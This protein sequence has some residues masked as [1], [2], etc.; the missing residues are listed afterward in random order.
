M[1]RRLVLAIVGVAAGAVAL[2]G[3]PLA[4]VL[5]NAYRG[6]ALLRLQRDAV[7]VTRSVDLSGPA[8]DPVELPAVTGVQ[9]SVY[10]RSTRRLAGDGPSRADATVAAALRTGRVA[11]T[12]GGG[13]L[14]VA[15]PLL[16]GERVDGALRA[17]RS[18]AEATGEAHEAWTLIAAIAAGVIAVAALAA[19]LAARRLA[20]PVER[21]APAA[22]RLGDGDFSAR[23]P[24]AGIAEIDAVAGA[25]DTT[26]QRLDDLL[27]RERAFSTNASHQLRTPLAALRLD[28]ESLALRASEPEVDRAL[29]QVDRLED[30]IDTMLAIARDAPTSGR[31][32]V[33]TLLRDS[34]AR[35]HGPLAAAARPLRI[36]PV[37]AG[38]VARISPGAAREIVDVLLDNACRHG[39]GP[40]MVLVRATD[41]TVA[42]EVRDEGSGF[43]E[44]SDPFARSHGAPD[45]DG[46]GL[47]L[48]LARSL[49]EAE[50]GRLSVTGRGDP[51]VLTLLLRR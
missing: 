10:D 48:R 13:W 9:L 41:A 5:D 44:D 24:R 49:A 19:V 45:D 16:S 30:T 31:T 11:D 17:R 18:S 3:V 32:D 43:P 35:W 34:A 38:C 14:T 6:D 28:L 21:L 42:I 23:A 50:G 40:V 2:F 22:T 27:A 15:V 39:D 7:A 33:G 25:L 29:E 26:A 37:P 46:H 51:T 1:R 8:G 12:Q 4:L 36:G 20:G 47:G